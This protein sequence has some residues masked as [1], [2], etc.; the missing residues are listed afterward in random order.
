M[1]LFKTQ[2]RQCF[3]SKSPFTAKTVFIDGQ[4]KLQK[5]EYITSWQHFITSQYA[6]PIK[7]HFEAGANTVILSFDDYNHVPKAKNMTQRKRCQ[8]VPVLEFSA[9]ESLP[10]TIPANWQ[11]AIMNRSFKTKVIMLVI[12][13]LP[14]FLT[15]KQ[16][17]QLFI[18]YQGSPIVF[19]GPA[20]DMYRDERYGPL[21]ESDVKFS[22]YMEHFDDLLLDS[23][24]GDY[25]PIAML[26]YESLLKAGRQ[27][28]VS[29]LRMVTTLPTDRKRD[30]EGKQRRQYEYLHVSELAEMLTTRLNAIY[31]HPSPLQLLSILIALTGTD[32]TKG[33]P[34]IGPSKFWDRLPAIWKDLSRSFEDEHLNYDMVADKVVAWVYANCY[35]NHVTS[36]MCVDTVLRQIHQS[37]KLSDNTKKSIPRSKQAIIA[38]LQN[39]HWVLLYWKDATEVPNPLQ[40]GFVQDSRGCMQWQF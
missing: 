18:D 12:E 32:F 36:I 35:K 2:Y 25:A 33:L 4:I 28:N 15:L 10:E 38:N 20:K 16:G 21:G 26:K 37:R 34:R 39:C 6:L 3:T 1:K 5:S 11:S 31:S 29:I 17:Q 22:R 30:S 14:N 40:Y 23:I 7:R 9:V 27:I 24:D 13:V 8:K 19:E